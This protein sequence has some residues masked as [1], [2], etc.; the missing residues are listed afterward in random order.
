M[1]L[2]SLFDVKPFPFLPQTGPAVFRSS[3]GEEV[4]YL[5][6]ASI[7]STNETPL[8]RRQHFFVMPLHFYFFKNLF[9]L[10]GP[11]DDERGAL[12]AHVF[13]SVKRFFLP[14]AVALNHLFLRIGQKGEIERLILFE[15]LV[16]LDRVRAHAQ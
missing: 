2:S 12:N 8:E 15:F 16:R 14:N 7:S 6:P 10:S 5:L 4:A 9:N 1:F 13:F 11:A 3:P